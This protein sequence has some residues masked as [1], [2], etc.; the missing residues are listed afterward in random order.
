MITK[1]GAVLK[2]GSTIVDDEPS[3]NGLAGGL[4]NDRRVYRVEHVKGT[5]LWLQDE[6]S[7]TAGWVTAEWLVPFDQAIEYFT[8]EIRANPGG[9][10]ALH[11]SRAHLAAEEGI[12]S[13]VR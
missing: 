4:R 1:S 10:C 8:N 13:R 11:P 12:R 5:W 2:V 3:D 6:K 7:N 9:A